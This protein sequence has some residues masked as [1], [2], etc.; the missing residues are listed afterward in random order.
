MQGV[1]QRQDYVSTKTHPLGRGWRPPGEPE[2][3]PWSSLH[4]LPSPPPL[5]RDVAG[6]DP[7]ASGAVSLPSQTPTT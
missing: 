5:I 3:T 2:A 6:L 4:Q 1:S 7:R